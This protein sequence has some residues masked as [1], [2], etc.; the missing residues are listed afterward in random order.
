MSRLTELF[1]LRSLLSPAVPPCLSCGKPNLHPVHGYPEIC[2]VCY[3]AIPW[4][5][6]IRCRICGR[7]VGCPD[8]SREGGAAST[9]QFLLNR[10]VVTYSPIMR[11]WLAQFKFR[12]N[13]AYGPLFARMIGWAVNGLLAELASSK[14]RR[15]TWDAVT[16]VPISKDRMLE[17]GFNQAKILAAEAAR[18]A[19]SPMMN[20]LDRTQHT[21]KQSF[22]NRK[23][24]LHDLRHAFQP[25]PYASHLLS[26]I[27]LAKNRLPH[28]LVNKPLSILLIDDV[29]TTGSTLDACT[30]V[31]SEICTGLGYSAEVYC[32]TW[33]RS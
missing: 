15:S 26:G 32:L 29:Y 10:S 31:L 28:P 5:T 1:S 7:P 24:R 25:A 18:E 4:I 3:A 2:K 6:N 33:A 27:Q 30:S 20:L 14:G 12:G 23:D 8:C 11:E 21:V 19:G 22:K 13:E 17:R 16:Y 9:R